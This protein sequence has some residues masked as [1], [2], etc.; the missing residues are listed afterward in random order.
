[1][2]LQW[3]GKYL[4]IRKQ[5]TWEYAARRGNM[6]AAVILAVTEAREIVLVEQ[7]RHA[8]G[9]PCIELPAGLIGDTDAGD[10][11]AA[12]AA[13]ELHEE[14][15]FE[16]AHWQDFGAFATSPGMSSEMFTLF[17]ATGLTRSGAGGGVDHENITVH[18]VDLNAI[19]GFLGLQRAAG[20]IIDC[21]LVVAL[22]LV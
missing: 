2:T 11:P 13:R 22:G 17:K 9:A 18:I 16:A 6:G 14:T 12:A 19:S 15:G 20:K 3:Q 4:E 10:T 1:M 7:F 5:G 21:R 8:H